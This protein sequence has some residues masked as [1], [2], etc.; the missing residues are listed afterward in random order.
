MSVT[1]NAPTLER[2]LILAAEGALT[3]RVAGT[4][5][6]T[7]FDKAFDGMSSG[8]RGRWVL[9]PDGPTD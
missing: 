6:L 3:P 2:L 7:E 9:L 8:G 5:P 4:M 1:S